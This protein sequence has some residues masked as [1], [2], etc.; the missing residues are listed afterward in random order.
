MIKASPERVTYFKVIRRYFVASL[1][2][3][4]VI[5]ALAAVGAAVGTAQTFVDGYFRRDGTYV[6][7]HFRYYRS[8]PSERPQ[9]L[10]EPLCGPGDL[11]T[12]EAMRAARELHTRDPFEFESWAVSLIE[13]LNSNQQQRG[14]GGIDGRG[15]VSYRERNHLI[16]AQVKGGRRSTGPVTIRAFSGVIERERADS[17]ILIVFSRRSLTRGAWTEVYERN[18]EAVAVII[19][20][21]ILPYLQVWSVEELMCKHATLIGLPHR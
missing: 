2:G 7:P 10:V 19:G 1:V 8:L 5:V 18:R 12:P 11:A 17:G 3:A 15:Y 6:H 16:L 21:R 4:M 13:G 9:P 20:Q 14:D